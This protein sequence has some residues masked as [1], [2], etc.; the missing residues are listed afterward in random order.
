MK[1]FVF[2]ALCLALSPPVFAATD[3][4]DLLKAASDRMQAVHT[5]AATVTVRSSYPSEDGET[6]RHVSRDITKVAEQRPNLITSSIWFGPDRSPNVAGPPNEQ[7]LSDGKAVYMIKRSTYISHP[8]RE[9]P[10]WADTPAEELNPFLIKTE[11]PL[12]LVENA[13]KRKALNFIRMAHDEVWSGA[14][15]KALEFEYTDDLPPIPNIKDKI[16]VGKLVV[17]VKCYI[18]NDRLVHRMIVH[19]NLDIDEEYTLDEIRLDPRIEA[20]EF[21]LPKDAKAEPSPIP[22]LANGAVVPDFSIVDAEGK[23]ATLASFK[24]KPIVIDF[25]AT[26]CAPCQMSLPSIKKLADQYKDKGLVI[27]AINVWDE[28]P[29]FDK[30]VKDHPEYGVFTILRDPATGRRQ[31]IASRLFHISGIPTQFVIDR[32]GKIAASFVGY[33]GDEHNLEKAIQSVLLR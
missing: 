26:W 17:D 32:D 12:Q 23:P 10:I 16:K 9:Y 24:G 25:W 13:R 20:A 19:N 28:K 6:E 11:G 27:L 29:A 3:P 30:W 4:V 22:L 8:I 33:G 15:H 14:N 5:F 21:V 18:G 31:A 2:A 1:P 7:V